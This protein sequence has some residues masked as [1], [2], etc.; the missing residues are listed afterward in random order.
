VA[1]ALN[2][3]DNYG[4]SWYGGHRTWVKQVLEVGPGGK[5]YRRLRGATE[6]PHEQWIAVPVID[7]G[8]PREVVEVAR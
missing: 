2:P 3:E 1:A 4:I 6:K 8:L 5:R 7:S